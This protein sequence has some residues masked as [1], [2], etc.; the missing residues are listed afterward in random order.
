MMRPLTSRFW[1][2]LSAVFLLGILPTE[3][4]L[5]SEDV[6]SELSPHGTSPLVGSY[7][8]IDARTG[9]LPNGLRY[10]ILPR[11]SSEPGIGIEM[12]V[13]GGFIAERRPGE[14][15]LVHFI[16]HM[17]FDGTKNIPPGQLLEIG[18]PVSFPAPTAGAT[19]WRGSRYYFS[20]RTSEVKDIDTLLF[21]LREFASE[22]TL[23][24]EAIERQRADVLRE[25]DEKQIGNQIY[26]D[27]VAA[28]GPGTPTDLI[29]AQNSQDVANAPIEVI[30]ALY[31]DLY[32]PVSTVIS[33][34]GDVD[35]DAVIAL[36]ED[37]F[38]DWRPEG[39]RREP[40][41]EWELEADKISN[42]SVAAEPRS[43]IGTALSWSL[44][45]S[46]TPLRR[47]VALD[48][49]L[50][51]MLAVE[52][53]SARF[54]AQDPDTDKSN[55]RVSIDDGTNGYR[56]VLIVL[57]QPERDW[58]ASVSNLSELAC[59]LHSRGFSPDEWRAA[60]A[61]TLASLHDR[62]RAVGSV[63]NVALAG[64]LA[65]AHS[66][67]IWVFSPSELLFHATKIFPDLDESR[68]NVWLR[69]RI[70][71]GVQ[72]LRVETPA[73]SAY[74]NP[75]EIVRKEFGSQSCE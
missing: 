45:S 25:M 39:T 53:L 12:Y 58:V 22:Q 27:L 41:S 19:D 31:R 8:V 38:G 62:A 6:Q 21:I 48:A 57:V 63:T 71:S 42:L 30:E 32:H 44:P 67:G 47:L 66:R 56:L 40:S 46:D 13:E 10:V 72:H 3:G 64:Q 50:M 34:V 2:T 23:L 14:R 29:D 73:L 11:K 36:I 75:T 5:A 18:M 61:S 33:V 55:L 43:R 15:G 7:E 60:K 59:S 28:V 49:A 54:E 17:A 4:S 70:I 69:D 16:E 68:G 9:E 37:R 26:A 1:V 51:D 20:S 65:N 74:E 24:P 35:P 52:A